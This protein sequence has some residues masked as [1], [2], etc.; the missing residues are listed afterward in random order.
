MKKKVEMEK[1][2]INNMFNPNLGP[3][4]RFDNNH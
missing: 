4:I 3:D 1:P 2:Q